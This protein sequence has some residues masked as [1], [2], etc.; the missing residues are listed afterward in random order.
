MKSPTERNAQT[1]LHRFADQPKGVRLIVG[2]GQVE[3]WSIGHE[4]C[5]RAFGGDH[6]QGRLNSNIF[7]SQSMQISIQQQQMDGSSSP[8]LEANINCNQCSSLD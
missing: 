7:F 1:D 2:C 8:K 4:G 5:R 6:R 3:T